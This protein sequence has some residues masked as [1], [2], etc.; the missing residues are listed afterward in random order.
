[1][2]HEL[3]SI[4]H[5]FTNAIPVE[6]R[7]E[8]VYS[9]FPLHRKMGALRRHYL[10][11]EDGHCFLNKKSRCDQLKMLLN[12]LFFKFESERP[13]TWFEAMQETRLFHAGL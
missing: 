12:Y 2:L 13:L 3:C 9:L 11:H 10:L 8:K 1:M 4:I 7:L 6:N 5:A